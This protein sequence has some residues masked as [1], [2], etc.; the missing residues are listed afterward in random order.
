MESRL[1]YPDLSPDFAMRVARR[2]SLEEM[3]RGDW[4]RF[5]TN[6]GLGAPFVRRRV[7]E[8]ADLALVQATAV[9]AELARPGLDEN[10]LAG[11]G[12]RVTDRAR[13]LALTV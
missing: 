4:D 6:A 7:R 1:A 2:A 3:R 9:A 5:A 13:R 11:C 10:A 12:A 8:L